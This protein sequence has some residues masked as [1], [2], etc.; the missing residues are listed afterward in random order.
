MKL[1]PIARLYLQLVSLRELFITNK[2]DMSAR[3]STV[4]FDTYR[5]R[6]SAIPLLH[7]KQPSLPYLNIPHI[8]LSVIILLVVNLVLESLLVG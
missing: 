8:L 7:S 5:Y 6:Y 3:F 2:S 4:Y 1:T